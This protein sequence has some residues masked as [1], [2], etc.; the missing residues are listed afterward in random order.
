MYFDI[1]F[2]VRTVDGISKIIINVEAQKKEP[3]E[4]DVEMRGIFYA[5]RELSSQ[6]HR[7]FSDQ[8]YN[9]IKKVY[10]IWIVMN[11]RENTIDKIHLHK[12]DLLGTSRWKPMYDLLNV[13]IIRMKNTLTSDKE[14][15]LHRLL[16]AL[17]VEDISLEK[18]NDVL[19]EFG[20]GLKENR[21]RMVKSM[22]NLGEGIWERG[23]EHGIEQGIE[24][25]RI[26]IARA[27]L[28]VIDIPTIAKKTG[29]TVE[30][31][32]ALAVKAEPV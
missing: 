15:E 10:S 31:V 17:F 2:Y 29:L 11:T 22:C 18:R 13:V 9:E 30:E 7:E 32:Q 24:Q 3:R 21:E 14:R 4:Y 16:G 25:E 12:E 1:L 20:I 27:F 8:Q 26:K 28:D 19:E 23:V 5:S 6:L